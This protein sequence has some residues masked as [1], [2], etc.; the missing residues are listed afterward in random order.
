MNPILPRLTLAATAVAAVIS[1]ISHLAQPSERQEGAGSTN[2]EAWNLGRR[3]AAALVRE[4]S[5]D[6][7]RALRLLDVRARE[8]N[9]RARI[10]DSAA[11]DYI[12]G[13]EEG[14]RENSDSLACVI[15]E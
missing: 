9:I 8:T 15:L 7:Q 3:H 13:F 5:D 14:L 6:D 2:M 12:R 1:A 10:S 4:C 11:D